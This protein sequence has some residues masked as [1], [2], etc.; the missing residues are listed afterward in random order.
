MQAGAKK[1]K[2]KKEDEEEVQIEVT[3]KLGGIGVTVTSLDGDLSH[4]IV[5]GKCLNPLSSILAQGK[6]YSTALICQE[7]NVVVLEVIYQFNSQRKVP[8]LRSDKL[9][10]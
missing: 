2:K 8:V 6:Y 4:I 3:A 9:P 1:S 7:K 5:G 10:W